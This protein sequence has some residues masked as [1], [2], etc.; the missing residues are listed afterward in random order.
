MFFI[1]DDWKVFGW[2]ADFNG[3]MAL[4]E[5]SL[6]YYFPASIPAPT[7]GA[8]WTA[9]SC[10][11]GYSAGIANVNG[12]GR[13]YEWGDFSGGAVHWNISK[14]LS[15]LR[16]D[17]SE[18]QSW[19]SVALGSFCGGALSYG[20]QIYTWGDRRRGQR[21]NYSTDSISAVTYA[22][23]SQWTQLACGVDH[24][25]AIANGN[26]IFSWGFNLTGQ[27][28]S[29]DTLM[30]FTPYEIP[31][32]QPHHWKKVFASVSSSFALSDDGR[33]F[34]WGSNEWG[35][36]TR[37]SQIVT[38]KTPVEIAF[39]AQGGY[40]LDIACGYNTIVGLGSDS[41]VYTWGANQE[42]EFWQDIFPHRTPTRVHRPY[43]V[44]GWVRIGANYHSAAALAT[45]H[46]LYC[47]GRRDS[48]DLNHNR[49][50]KQDTLTLLLDFNPAFVSSSLKFASAAWP[51]PIHKN[52][53]LHLDHPNGMSSI[54]LCDILGREIL[55]QAI[56]ISQSH[57]EIFIPNLP[58]GIYILRS[59]TSQWKVSVSD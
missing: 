58:N 46:K 16:I 32:T 3:M 1:S 13:L 48:G 37:D 28:G 31:F 24:M 9:I 53:R 30:R 44:T 27:L 5:D 14:S 17:V 21:G 51:T 7:S 35:E 38:Q 49:R 59:G 41:E 23:V 42:G 55:R 56:N 8:G 54:I 52:S 18:V 43:G 10:G 57:S 2:G 11:F 22:D 12:F 40:W 19:K 50:I 25:L 36:L 39:P 26:R 45:N 47:W 34:G 29:G 6:C 33:L 4:G 15:P 20:G